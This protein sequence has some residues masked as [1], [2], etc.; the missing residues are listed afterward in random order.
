MIASTYYLW[1]EMK[2]NV[3]IDLYKTRGV[4][5]DWKKH[6]DYYSHAFGNMH[7]PFKWAT[8][9][10]TFNFFLT[11][12]FDDSARDEDFLMLLRL[13]AQKYWQRLDDQKKWV[14]LCHWH[15][16]CK[17]EKVMELVN[18]TAMLAALGMPKTMPSEELSKWKV[19]KSLTKN[20]IIY[21]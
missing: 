17:S 10:A 8:D 7:T 12:C 21:S 16:R 2:W 19:V 1:R 18:I 3:L 6:N 13:M 20:L 4:F 5:N 15:Y 11:L 9:D 14:V